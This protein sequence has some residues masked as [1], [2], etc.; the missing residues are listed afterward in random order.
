MSVR[1]MQKQESHAQAPSTSGSRIGVCRG[2]PK[3]ICSAYRKKSP[4]RLCVGLSYLRSVL[5]GQHDRQKPRDDGLSI[6]V[7]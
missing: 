6:R 5:F 2:W 3:C 7:L 4:P 1:R